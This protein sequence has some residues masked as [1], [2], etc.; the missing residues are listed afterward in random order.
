MPVSEV[1][2]VRVGLAPIRGRGHERRRPP[3]LHGLRPP[4]LLL[5]LL[6][7]VLLVLDLLLLLLLL[8]GRAEPVEQVRL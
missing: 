8:V 4:A 6:L 1:H 5:L 2:V 7:L 3:A